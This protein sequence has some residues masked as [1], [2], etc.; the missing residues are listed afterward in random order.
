MYYFTTTKTF[1]KEKNMYPKREKKDNI[2][3][4][5]C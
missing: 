3:K 5:K 2:D 4:Q 1:L